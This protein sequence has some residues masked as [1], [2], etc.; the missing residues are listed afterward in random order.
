MKKRPIKIYLLEFIFSIH[1]D[2]GSYAGFG[3]R[4]GTG[5]WEDGDGVVFVRF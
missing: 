2:I 1:F 3:G 5:G 4:M